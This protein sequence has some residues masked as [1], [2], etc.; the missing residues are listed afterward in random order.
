MILNHV[1]NLYDNSLHSDV[2]IVVDEVKIPA[3]RYILAAHSQVFMQ[4]WEHELL[5]VK[6]DI[7]PFTE[8]L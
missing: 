2:S 7:R 1:A 3:H 8:G 5:E 4:M 6:P